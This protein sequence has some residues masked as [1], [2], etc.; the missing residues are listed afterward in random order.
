MT[1]AR[2]TPLLA[3]AASLLAL[4][5]ASLADDFAPPTYRGSPL[6]VT[7][8]WE[9]QNPI[10]GFDIPTTNFTSNGDGISILYPGFTTKA[11]LN[12]PTEWTWSNYDGDGAITAVNPN[13]SSIA[14]KV[15]NWIDLLPDKFLR[16]QITWGGQAPPFGTILDAIKG[17]PPTVYHG[18]LLSSVPVDATHFYEDWIIHPNPD[19]ESFVLMVPFNT[20]LDEVIIDTV[21]LPAPGAAACFIATLAVLPR[22]RPIAS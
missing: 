9:F 14:F 22:R 20:A 3:A 7:A 21:S 12:S 11:E 8:E 17:V 15:Q 10:S 1:S 19:W 18:T 2:I 16:I 6:S 5:P 13:G 4:A